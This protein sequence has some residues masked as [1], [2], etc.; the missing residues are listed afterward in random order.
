MI[1]GKPADSRD[2]CRG[3]YVAARRLHVLEKFPRLV[4][5]SIEM[6]AEVQA[7]LAKG[8]GGKHP[9][10]RESMPVKGA[11]H[12]DGLRSARTTSRAPAELPDHPKSQSDAPGF[13]ECKEHNLKFKNLQGYK[14]HITSIH[15]KGAKA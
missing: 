3:H 8:D 11:L 5:S 9:K 15:L 12:D 6:E 10:S 13:L 4:R 14:H 2:L 1:C 7:Y